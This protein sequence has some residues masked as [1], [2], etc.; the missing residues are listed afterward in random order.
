MGTSITRCRSIWCNQQLCGDGLIA[1][2]P[3]CIDADAIIALIRNVAVLQ[4]KAAEPYTARRGY[5]CNDIRAILASIEQSQDNIALITRPEV[6]IPG[7]RV[8]I[9]FYPSCSVCWYTEWCSISIESVIGRCAS[10]SPGHAGIE[11]S[12]RIG[13]CGRRW[14]QSSSGRGD[15]R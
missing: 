6:W 12:G 11:S 4:P 14:M 13:N 9:V 8:A 3:I 1:I 5:L 2:K 10:W 7:N 15:G